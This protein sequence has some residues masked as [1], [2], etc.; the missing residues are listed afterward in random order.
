LFENYNKKSP[1]TTHANELQLHIN[2]I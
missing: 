2:C 1:Q